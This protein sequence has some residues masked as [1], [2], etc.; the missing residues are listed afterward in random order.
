MP[1]C[2]PARTKSP[3]CPGRASGG[4]WHGTAL[5]TLPRGDAPPTGGRVAFVAVDG[6]T[7][8]GFVIADVTD[9][10]AIEVVGSASVDGNNVQ[11]VRVTPDGRFAVLNVQALPEAGFLTTPDGPADCGACLLVWNIEDRTAPRLVSALPVELLGTHNMEFHGF[12]DGLYLFYV[13]QPLAGTNPDPAGNRIGIARFEELPG[14][15][16]A[17]VNVGTLVHDT[18][19]DDGRSF[20]H[21]V[22]VSEHPLTGQTVAYASC[23]RGGAITF[24]VTTPASRAQP[25]MGRSADPAPSSALAIHW[26]A[27]EP[28]GG[29]A[30]RVIAPRAPE[31]QSLD[32]GT[33]VIR[34]YDASDP[35]HL[36][37]LGTWQLPGSLTIE[38]RFLL[39]PHVAVP[40][41]DTGLLAVAH[42]HAGVW[43]LDMSDPAHPQALGY[44]L[45]H[46]PADHPYDA[47]T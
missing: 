47:P 36:V 23:W 38:G 44:Y 17:L 13:G 30:G 10:G 41:Q 19:F 34:S 22:S 46:G 14:G 26:L 4:P 3:L 42:Y 43:V 29:R 8:G 28:E 31:I 12:P 20:P 16:A 45:P 32:D 9:P 27:Q 7:R 2:T 18:P 5:P 11:E 39:S 24:G 33:G 15:G 1:A 6:D 37:Q 35:R 21:D 25:E 40:D